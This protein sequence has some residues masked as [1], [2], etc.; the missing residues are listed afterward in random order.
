[1][2]GEHYHALLATHQDILDAYRVYEKME[3]AIK[4]AGKEIVLTTGQT[5][6]G[7]GLTWKLV[8]TNEKVV[9]NTADLDS[10]VMVLLQNGQD[11]VARRIAEARSVVP[12]TAYVRLDRDKSKPAHG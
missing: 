10:L 1:M 11:E 4:E 5:H 6:A 3:K 12:G 2:L 8:E 7:V 9:W